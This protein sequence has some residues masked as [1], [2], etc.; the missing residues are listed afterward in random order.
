MRKV[1][2]KDAINHKYALFIKGDPIRASGSFLKNKTHKNQFN[3]Q[4]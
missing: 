4:K 1:L 3:N 2:E